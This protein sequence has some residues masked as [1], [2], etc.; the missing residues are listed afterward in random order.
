VV[1]FIIWGGIN[2]AVFCGLYAAVLALRR[3][4][5]NPHDRGVLI[6]G[7]CWTLLQSL[8][9][10]LGLAAGDSMGLSA[11]VLA[12][13]GA[14]GL[15]TATLVGRARRSFVPAITI[16]VGTAVAI[17]LGH[18]GF[19]GVIT[20]NF[21]WHMGVLIAISITPPPAPIRRKP[22]WICHSCGYDLSGL[23]SHVPC[24]ECGGRREGQ[25]LSEPITP[26]LSKSRDARP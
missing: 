13:I 1:E 7:A 12:M 26:L 10:W 5:W 4:E 17:A 19:E 2:A 9:M 6:W 14:P 24:P 15:I 23:W 22:A 25:A 8:F 3:L 21:T 11:A 16:T 20:G 18:R